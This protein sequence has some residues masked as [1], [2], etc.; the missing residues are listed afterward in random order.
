MREGDGLRKRM[1][2]G[3]PWLRI[4]LAS[5]TIAAPLITRWNDLRAAERARSLAEEAEARLHEMRSWTPWTRDDQAKREAAELVREVSKQMGANRGK[6]SSRVWL[7]GVGVGLVAAGTGAYFLVRRR[8]ALTLEE[9][10]VDLP[11]GSV[12]G[13]TSAA[14]A[15]AHAETTTATPPEARPAPVATRPLPETAEPDTPP[16]SAILPPGERENGGVSLLPAGAPAGVVNADE[17]PFIGNI[18]TMVYH[19]ADDPDL[20]AEE[21]RIYFASEEEARSASYRRHRDEIPP[22]EAQA[23]TSARESSGGVS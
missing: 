9:P 3:G 16:E 21:N 15:S 11:V 2:A 12:N 1:S 5:A 6:I 13:R 23:E 19:E 17:A 10:L 4:G 8:L 14:P 18:R 20:P 22:D 7:V